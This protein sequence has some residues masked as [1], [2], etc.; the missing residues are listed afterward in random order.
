LANRLFSIQGS[1]G[2]FSSAS[3]FL[4]GNNMTVQ[5]VLA[6]AQASTQAGYTFQSRI[7]DLTVATG[8]ALWGVKK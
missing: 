4:E 3:Q 7:D 6:G 1:D 8:V 2:S 5:G